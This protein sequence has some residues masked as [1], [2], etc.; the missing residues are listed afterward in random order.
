[1]SFEHHRNPDGTY[2]GVGVMS[3]VSGLSQETVADIARKVQANHKRLNGCAYHD[4]ELC[5][6][7]VSASHTR[8]RCTHCGGEVSGHDYKWH[9]DGRRPKP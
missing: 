1:M 7:S 9:Q 4:F 2:N 3:E 5:K 6:P 8:Y